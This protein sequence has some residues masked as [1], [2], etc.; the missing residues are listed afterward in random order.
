M[1]IVSVDGMLWV[2]PFYK[3]FLG[4]LAPIQQIESGQTGWLHTKGIGRGL[5][6]SWVVQIV[7]LDLKKSYAAFI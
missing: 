3:P 6:V 2:G 1:V 7:R 4:S 5:T